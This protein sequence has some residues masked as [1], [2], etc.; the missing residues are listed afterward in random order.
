MRP[1]CVCL[2][3]FPVVSVQAQHPTPRIPR[4]PAFESRNLLKDTI[5]IGDYDITVY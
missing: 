5:I 2:E 3:M 4:G 1:V